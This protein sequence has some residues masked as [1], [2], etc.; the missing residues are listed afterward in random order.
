MTEPVRSTL[1]PPTPATEPPRRSPTVLG[2]LA[3]AVRQQSWFAVAVE[4]AVVVLGVVIGFQVTAWGQARADR[5]KEQIYLRQLAADLRETERSVARADSSL[6]PT[7]RSG[8]ELVRAYYRPEPPPRDSL[9]RWLSNTYWSETAIPIVSTAEAL[10]AT[11]DLGLIRDDTLRSAITGYLEAMQDARDSQQDLSDRFAVAAEPLFDRIDLAL[12]RTE[13]MDPAVVD[14]L[15]RANPYYGL[16][17]GPRRPLRPVDV[18]A[19]LTD[20]GTRALLRRMNLMK[21]NLRWVREDIADETAA[22]LRRVEAQ[23][24]R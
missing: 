17:E 2:R 8:A 12:L 10:V 13:S 19:L 18:R 9:L 5:A 15:A 22:L 7:D 16:P 14:S 4:V 20:D 23:T 24:D 11:G 21:Q 3:E 6:A 1:P